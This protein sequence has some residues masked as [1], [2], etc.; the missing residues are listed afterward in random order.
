[1][2][3]LLLAFDPFWA[4]IVAVVLIYTLHQCLALRQDPLRL[5]ALYQHKDPGPTYPHLPFLQGLDFVFENARNIVRRRFTAGVHQR[6]EQYGKTHVSHI[7]WGKMVNTIDPENLEAVMTIDC[8]SWTIIP[9]RALLVVKVF[10][11]GIFANE[12]SDWKHSRYLIR[13]GMTALAYRPD[14]LEQHLQGLLEGVRTHEGNAFDFAA[15]AFRYSF[16]AAKDL[17][18]GRQPVRPDTESPSNNARSQ[19][20]DD[21]ANLVKIAKVLTLLHRRIPY[22]ANI[23]FWN[24][25]IP[26]KT[27]VFSTVDFQTNKALQE[28]HQKHQSDKEDSCLIQNLALL[29]NDVSRIRSEALNML[30][31]GRDS[32]GIA[33][34]ETFVPHSSAHQLTDPL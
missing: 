27:R 4:P 32:V 18:I 26:A 28:S 30:L 12:G 15:H 6:F 3:Y 11:R 25:F 1:M 31:G 14:V 8:D 23:L 9:Q 16:D 2:A 34:S 20:A 19:F 24:T 21:F 7:F 13:R 33:L 29:T 17:L 10:G 22:L 5:S